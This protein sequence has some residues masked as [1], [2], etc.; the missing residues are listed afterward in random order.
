[1]SGTNGTPNLITNGHNT[2]SILDV[3]FGCPVN[4]WEYSEDSLTKA[5]HLKQEQ[6]KT[7][8]Q[9]YK[10]ENVNKSIELL[11]LA[12]QYDIPPAHIIR[13]FNNDE[14][15]NSNSNLP[16]EIPNDTQIGNN[17]KEI[18]NNPM[19]IKMEPL[20]SS[21]LLEADEVQSKQP[22][23]YKFPPVATYLPP[24][25]V[26]KPRQKRTNSP[27]RIGA[28][29]VAALSESNIIKEEE[30]SPNVSMINMSPS[31]HRT[32]TQ[33]HRRNFSLPMQSISDSYSG[34]TSILNFSNVTTGSNELKQLNTNR[35][36]FDELLPQI[37][38]HRRSR[39]VQGFNVIDLNVIDKVITQ[40]TTSKANIVDIIEIDE[41]A[42][43]NT[44]SEESSPHP[45][46]TR[47]SKP[48]HFI[49]KLLNST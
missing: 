24:R 4:P 15:T 1:M 27:A 22:T 49:K 8:Q 45:S 18:I 38:K 39:T 35:L 41:N 46:P 3:V 43:D 25:Q 40:P 32:A 29:A 5:L 21:Q 14:V 9:Y 37:R 26:I 34:M 44:C 6:E 28:T 42:D 17:K 13:L 30:V 48:P 36:P 19:H 31:L 12:T 23:S 47:A 10:L 11:K 16:R 2:K 7:K 20:S 33:S